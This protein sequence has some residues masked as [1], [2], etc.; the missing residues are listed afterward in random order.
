MSPH[1]V[2]K[3]ARDKAG[4]INEVTGDD[5]VSR[6]SIVTRDS[7]VLG[8]DGDCVYVLLEGREDGVDRAKELF[9]K[10]DIGRAVPDK[11]ANDVRDAIKAEE[12]SAAEGMGSLFG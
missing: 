7:N 9:E 10:G 5:I 4:Q 3:V 1:T 12:D 2:I 6:L 8:I 11:V